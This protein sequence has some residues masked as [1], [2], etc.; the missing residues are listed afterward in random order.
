MNNIDFSIEVP[1][2][3]G[4][5]LLWSFIN[6]MQQ[7]LSCMQ[8]G[9]D[10][11]KCSFFNNL[12]Y[13]AYSGHDVTLTSLFTALGFNQTNWDQDGSPLYSSCVTVELWKK[14]DNTNYVKVKNEIRYIFYFNISVHV[15]APR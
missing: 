1:K 14:D 7:K 9:T 12:K 2:I 8:N 4:G 15:L 13:Y 6:N 3:R 11:D 10:L 5:P